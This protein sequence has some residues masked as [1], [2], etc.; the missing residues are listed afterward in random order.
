[1]KTVECVT[2]LTPGGHITLPR[3]VAARLKLK[4]SARVHLSLRFDEETAI[5]DLTRFCGAWRD[6]RGAEEIIEE[7]RKDRNHSTR[8]ERAAF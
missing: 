4:K 2:E 1:M 6:S 8:S 3:D 7:I 5:G